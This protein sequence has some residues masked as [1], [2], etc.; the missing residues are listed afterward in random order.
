[1]ENIIFENE[2]EVTPALTKK[3][4]SLSFK[5][6]ARYRHWL[7]IILKIIFAALTIIC[8]IKLMNDGTFM[9]TF[10][11]ITLAFLLMLFMPKFINKKRYK[12]YLK[13]SGQSEIIQTLRFG[14]KIEV[15]SGN[16]V[17]TYT[18][19]QVKFIDE[20]DD[21][22]CLWVNNAQ[23]LMI[24]KNAFKIG[25]ADLFREFIFEKC[26]ENKSL[27]T[28]KHLNHVVFK[29]QIPRIILLLLLVAL[30]TIYIFGNPHSN[31]YNHI[32]NNG[33]IERNYQRDIDTIYFTKW[34][35]AA[36]KGHTA[37][38]I[39]LKNNDFYYIGEDAADSKDIWGSEQGDVD[40][41]L[42]CDLDN[43]K[44]DMFFRET[45]RHGF[46]NW[47]ERYED[48]TILDGSEWYIKIVF[49]DGTIKEISG[50]NAYPETWKYVI[51]NFVNLTGYK[52]E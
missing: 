9:P 27:W 10:V 20:N 3:W 22:F 23:L 1:M 7:A 36:Q 44:V 46:T 6:S 18:Y 41:R 2:Y 47:D 19:D 37:Y 34:P 16:S 30:I 52:F 43:D 26:K 42:I 39:D 29:K 24:Y 33:T 25:N 48:L 50:Q 28:K 35:F 8:A 17:T 32:N 49:A 5:R 11:F 21:C 31:T 13:F 40:F 4:N 14:E 15:A 38:K 12:N 51:A 45:A